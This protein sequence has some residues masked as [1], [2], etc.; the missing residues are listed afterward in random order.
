MTYQCVGGLRVRVACSHKYMYRDALQLYDSWL[1]EREV[2][3]VRIVQ[4]NNAHCR[5]V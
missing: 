3:V 4:Y 5:A 1:K 2:P